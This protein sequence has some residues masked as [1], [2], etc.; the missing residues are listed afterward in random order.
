[1]KVAR[2]GHQQ[3][4]QADFSLRSLQLD[5][6]CAYLFIL[7]LMALSVLLNSGI[8]FNNKLQG[9][10]RTR[11]QQNLILIY[12]RGICLDGLRTARKVSVRID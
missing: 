12:Q 7:H 2:I 5:S 1:M 4:Q 10:T 9:Y 11:S 6:L 8:A 3:E